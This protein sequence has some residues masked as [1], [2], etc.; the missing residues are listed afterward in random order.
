[1]S[2]GVPTGRDAA[3]SEF[4]TPLQYYIA[5]LEKALPEYSIQAL[6]LT[7]KPLPQERKRIWILGSSTDYSAKTWVEDVL[8][9]DPKELPHHHIRA[10]FQQF[11]HELGARPNSKKPMPR[12]WVDEAA[13]SKA[14]SGY[15]DLAIQAKRLPAKHVPVAAPG[16]PSRSGNVHGLSASQRALLDVYGEMLTEMMSQIPGSATYDAYPCADISQSSNRGFMCVPGLIGTATTSTR[17]VQMKELKLLSGAGMMSVL[18]HDMS[19]KRTEGLTEADLFS[20]AGN[21]MCFVQLSR[22]LLPLIAQM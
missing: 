21:A 6:D 3:A 4:K 20:L 12:E 1:M 7:S 22:V 15:M 2:E 18:G 10:Y 14:F 5:T 8:R 17:L 16:R 9:T 13:Y 11:G 19:K